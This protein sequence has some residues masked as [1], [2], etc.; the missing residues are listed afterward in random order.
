[1][2]NSGYS[3][4]NWNG[5][6]SVTAEPCEVSQK[7]IMGYMAPILHPIT[8]Y[9]TVQQC[10]MTS[11]EACRKLNQ[12]YT[13]IT[14]DLA[15]AKIALDIVWSEP[16][17]FANVIVNLGAFHIMSAYVGA[18]GKMMTGSGLKTL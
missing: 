14:M 7:S 9:A 18:L 11:M 5:W 13:F 6:V 8:D 4:P 16:E 1:M 15:A 3:I 17:K 12:Q 2:Y 10:I